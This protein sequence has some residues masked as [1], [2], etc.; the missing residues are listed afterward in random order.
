MTAGR[1]SSGKK[2]ISLEMAGEQVHV[3]GTL[4][5]GTKN[6]IPPSNATR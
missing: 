3:V 2:W 1:R 5:E 6:D 4:T